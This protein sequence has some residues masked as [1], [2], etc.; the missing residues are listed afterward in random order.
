M[1]SD[2]QKPRYPT[3]VP[4]YSNKLLLVI[5]IFCN[6]STKPIAN[7]GQLLRILNLILIII[8]QRT[9]FRGGE[10]GGGLSRILNT[11]NFHQKIGELCAFTDIRKYYV[12]KRL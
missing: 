8:T 2:I 3:P 12:H 1:Y 10:G 7:R 6:V 4:F 9:I 11:C 5:Y